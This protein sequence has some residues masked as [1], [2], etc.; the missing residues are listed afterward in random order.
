MGDEV[1]GMD[2]AYVTVAEFEGVLDYFGGDIGGAVVFGSTWID[3]VESEVW[4]EAYV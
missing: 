3:E 4:A 2:G 1:R